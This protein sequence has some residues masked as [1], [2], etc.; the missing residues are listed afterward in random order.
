MTRW[1][2]VDWWL[3][4][5]GPIGL[6]LLAVPLVA[7]LCQVAV[8]SEPSPPATW[9]VPIDRAESALASGDA[10]A[11]LAAWH[12]AYAG[13]LRSR[14]WAPMIEVGDLSLRIG[15]ASGARGPAVA[16]ARQSYLIALFHARREGLLDGLIRAAEAFA[17]LGD[18]E[19]VEHALDLAEP[20]ARRTAPEAYRGTAERVRARAVAA[21]P[22]R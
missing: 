10:D 19:V 20:L 13:A 22:P 11:A 12:A 6:I 2:P 8:S 14:T 21:G 3:L 15:E 16:R 18:H 17:A 4:L 1:E 7:A 9:S 5:L